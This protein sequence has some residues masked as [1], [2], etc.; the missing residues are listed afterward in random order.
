MPVDYV[1]RS[2]IGAEIR[3]RAGAT[4]A[5]VAAG[6]KSPLASPLMAARVTSDTQMQR[7]RFLTT[8][9]SASERPQIVT[10]PEYKMRRSTEYKSQAVHHEAQNNYKA[11]PY[12][13]QILDAYNADRRRVPTD[14]AT[15]GKDLR[16][17]WK[18][19]IASIREPTDAKIFDIELE[20]R[21]AQAKNPPDS[22][23]MNIC[24]DQIAQLEKQYL[25]DKKLAMKLLMDEKLGGNPRKQRMERDWTGTLDEFKHEVEAEREIMKARHAEEQRDFKRQVLGYTYQNDK[26]EYIDVAGAIPNVA[27]LTAN[28][29]NEVKEM[30]STVASLVREQKWDEA[31]AKKAELDK[32]SIAELKKGDGNLFNSMK[33][34]KL[35]RRLAQLNIKQTMEQADFEHKV[36]SKAVGLAV[37]RVGMDFVE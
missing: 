17:Y 34:L 31:R 9:Q 35:D 18:D 11:V 23:K 6:L 20:Y 32:Q 21:A 28:V 22:Y 27:S 37:W 30:R 8:P 13:E 10:G 19:M 29:S 16:K 7:R 33:D 1:T 26:G 3:G 36:E 12:K 2:T 24:R 25:Y 5:T 15:D 4:A 14:K